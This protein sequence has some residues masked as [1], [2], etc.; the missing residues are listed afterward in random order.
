[1]NHNCPVC[2]ATLP[3]PPNNF[4]ICPCC[5]TEFEN[6][7]AD[8]THEELRAAWIVNGAHWLGRRVPAPSAWSPEEQLKAIGYS[9]T[10]NDRAAIAQNAS[11]QSG[12]RVSD[13]AA[14]S[15]PAV[16]I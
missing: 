9:L 6:D 15:R 11:G 4:H 7:D 5:R 12:V 3:W 14:N 1:M 2:G 10:T 8:M 13:S 16:C